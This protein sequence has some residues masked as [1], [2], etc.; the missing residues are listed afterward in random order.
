MKLRPDVASNI[1]AS[2]H[3][4]LVFTAIQGR[5][6]IKREKMVALGARDSL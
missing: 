5:I 4:T 1:A 6:F 2:V 3:S